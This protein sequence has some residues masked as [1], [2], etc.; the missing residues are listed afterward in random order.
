MAPAK[1][2]KEKKPEARMDVIR[3]HVANLSGVNPV[4]G[5]KHTHLSNK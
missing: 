2:R 1:T 3:E 4:L 5:I